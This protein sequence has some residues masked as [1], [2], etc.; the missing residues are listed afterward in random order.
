LLRASVLEVVEKEFLG[1]CA[2]PGPEV[3]QGALADEAALVF[4]EGEE[5]SR[6]P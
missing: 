4:D 5:I 2:S 6:I 1:R 3:S